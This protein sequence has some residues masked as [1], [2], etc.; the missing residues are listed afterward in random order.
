LAFQDYGT[1]WLR[2][3]KVRTGSR[4]KLSSVIWFCG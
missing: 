1:L 4:S 3:N 2:Q